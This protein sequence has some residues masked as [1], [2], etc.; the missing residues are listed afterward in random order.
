M[1]SPRVGFPVV[2]IPPCPAVFK[3]YPI[4][5]D[6]GCGTHN[7]SSNVS[8]GPDDDLTCYCRQQS[9]EKVTCALR[10]LTRVVTAGGFVI[11]SHSYIRTTS[12]EC[13]ANG[14]ELRRQSQC[15]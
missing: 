12:I 1:H 10:H 9:S 8:S 4:L 11:E 6:S 3:G 7:R 13:S 15:S 14:A 5:V 2:L